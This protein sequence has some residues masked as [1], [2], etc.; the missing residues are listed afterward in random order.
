M[1]EGGEERSTASPATD[2]DRQ[3]SR[4]TAGHVIGTVF[5]GIGA[6]IGLA[7]LVGGIGVMAAYAFGRDEGGYFTT[8]RKQLES[9]TYA[10]TSQDIDLGIDEV[11]WVPDEILGNIRLQ[12]ES[13]KPVFVGIGPD[14]DVDRY[15][16]DVAHDELI[17]FER[18]RPVFELRQGG[19]PRT[20]P[21]DQD[22]WVAEARGSG[23][24]AL[25]WDAKFGRWTAVMMNPNAARDI[26]VRA[27][28]G[29]KLEWAIWAGLGM[30]VVGL[31]MTAGG[32]IVIVI[33]SRHASRAPTEA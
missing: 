4:W 12:V 17:D 8:E 23:E 32:V 7:L 11:E 3:R 13:E 14:N 27:D 24:Q 15:L 10:I 9:A 26:D 29:I 33:I 6:L 18:D 2:P 30:S 21:E 5:G 25:T 16:G 20:P 19:A 1:T 22:F 31:L 28:A